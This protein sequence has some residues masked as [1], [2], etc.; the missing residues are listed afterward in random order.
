MRLILILIFIPILTFGQKKR[1]I[2]KI[3]EDLNNS[4]NQYSRLSP[5]GEEYLEIASFNLSKKETKE[6][7][8]EA[9]YDATLSKNKDSIQSYQ[10][11]DYFQTEIESSL[12]QILI[13]TD[14][15]KYNISELIT[16]DELHIVPSDDNK[17][18]NFS[19]D[20]KTGGTYRHRI[21]MMHYT[22]FDNNDSTNPVSFPSFFESDGYDEIYTL[23][24]DSG[25]K[26]VLTGGVRGCSYCFQTFVRLV[27]FNNNEFTEDFY[28]S[29]DLRDWNGGAYYN[30]ETKT[31]EVDYNIDDLT[32]YCYCNGALTE[33]DDIFIY[34]KYEKQ[35]NL[36]NC[37]CKFV[38]NGVNFELVEEGWKKIINEDLEE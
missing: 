2:E 31:I 1:S 20:A 6:L 25:V 18:F 3:A 8:V 35:E 7:L 29:V 12:N 23:Q 36:I 28:Y 26:Y 11:I 21:S 14:F 17:L 33:D 5:F 13:H 15:Q 32:P 30:H 38:F 16:S 19:F 10:M 37:K 24:S 22:D 34:N 4:L 27:S 9:N